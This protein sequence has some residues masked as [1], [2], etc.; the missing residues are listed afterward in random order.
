MLLILE[1]IFLFLK[2][3]A[4]IINV[5]EQGLINEKKW[6]VEMKNKILSIIIS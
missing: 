6:Q 4:N 1:I 3:R 2:K 5:S